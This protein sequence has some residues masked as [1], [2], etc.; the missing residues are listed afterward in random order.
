M[1]LNSLDL[2]SLELYKE[3]IR[4]AKEKYVTLHESNY[5]EIAKYA[6]EQAA[7][8]LEYA[9]KTKHIPQDIENIA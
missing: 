3:G 1:N 7:Y 8:F 9:K 4:E 2:I 5:T 6:Y